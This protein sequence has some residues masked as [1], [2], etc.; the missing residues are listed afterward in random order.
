MTLIITTNDN[1]VEALE[2]TGTIIAVASLVNYIKG[3]EAVLK[4]ERRTIAEVVIAT[5]QAATEEYIQQ[6]LN[7]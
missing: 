5:T 7:A 4:Q 1:K 2:F 3:A 6:K